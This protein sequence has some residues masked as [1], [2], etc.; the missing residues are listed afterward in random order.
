MQLLHACFCSIPGPQEV[1]FYG[2]SLS[3]L[4]SVFSELFSLSYMLDKEKNSLLSSQKFPLAYSW[5]L[6]I[7]LFSNLLNTCTYLRGRETKSSPLPALQTHTA[8]G[9]TRT[10]SEVFQAAEVSR[11]CLPGDL[12]QQEARV[13]GQPLASGMWMLGAGHLHTAHPVQDPLRGSL[14]VHLHLG[15]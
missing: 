2:V 14:L 1:G 8:A 7:C 10:G 15:T 5:L 3:L 6:S 9:L 4:T 12:P 11:H 13:P